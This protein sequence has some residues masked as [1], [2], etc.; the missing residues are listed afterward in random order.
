MD[1]KEKEQLQQLYNR[2]RATGKLNHPDIAPLVKKAIDRGLLIDSN[3]GK[4]RPN[5]AP[6]PGDPTLGRMAPGNTL[7]KKPAYPSPLN[8]PV[9]DVAADFPAAAPLQRS[10]IAKN[11]SPL[12][13]LA[14][15]ATDIVPTVANMVKGVVSIAGGVPMGLT[16]G[17]MNAKNAAGLAA[18]AR[19]AVERGDFKEAERLVKMAE[20]AQAESDAQRD[21]L[22]DMG[23][24]FLGGDTGMVAKM[25][26]RDM[27][28]RQANDTSLSPELRARYKSEAARLSREIPQGV[29]D[30]F[31]ENPIQ[32]ALNA[33][34]IMSPFLRAGV[35]ADIAANSARA[36][37]AA[38][39]AKAARAAGNVAEATRLEANAAKF[40]DAAVNAKK[41]LLGVSTID[42]TIQSLGIP[43][44]VRALDQAASKSKGYNAA[45]A[46]V[47]R[48]A[49]LPINIPGRSNL[50][51][52]LGGK[53]FSA[54]V[55]NEFMDLADPAYRS[56]QFNKAITDV[57]ADKA[58][59][60][61]YGV[62]Y[63]QQPD[64]TPP[65]DAPGIPPVE[66]PPQAGPTPPPADTPIPESRLIGRQVDLPGIEIP[67]DRP[68]V[69]LT[70]EQLDEAGNPIPVRTSQQ[71]EAGKIGAEPLDVAA[72]KK[73]QDEAQPVEAAL[74]PVEPA[75]IPVEPVVQ[76]DA[77]ARVESAPPA[78]TPEAQKAL[79]E[80]RESLRSADTDALLPLVQKHAQDPAREP[81]LAAV[82]DELGTRG[83][84]DEDIAAYKPRPTEP[85]AAPS[86]V[87]LTAPLTEAIAP[88]KM[89]PVVPR[90]EAASKPEPRKPIATAVDAQGRRVT[91]L[92]DG[93]DEPTAQ[94]LAARILHENADNK[95]LIPSA[96][97]ALGLDRQGRAAIAERVQDIVAAA[98]EERMAQGRRPDPTPKDL[99]AWVEK[100]RPEAIQQ[101]QAEAPTNQPERS[102]QR[103]ARIGGEIGP[104][105]EFYKGGAFIATTDLPKR[106]KEKITQAA[107]GV[108]DF[109]ATEKRVPV[110]GEIPIYGRV[111]PYAKGFDTLEIIPGAGAFYGQNE[112]VLGQLAEAFNRGER[113]VRAEDY[114]GIVRQSDIA[115]YIESGT[116]IPEALLEKVRQFYP[117]AI[118]ATKQD[119]LPR[120]LVEAEEARRTRQ[121]TAN[122]A[123]AQREV[124]RDV[125]DV[126][127]EKDAGIARK[128]E[129]QTAQEIGTSVTDEIDARES[130]SLRKAREAAEKEVGEMYKPTKTEEFSGNLALKDLSIEDLAKYAKVT[131]DSIRE[132]GGFGG[133]RSKAADGIKD[134]AYYIE[135]EM[136]RRIYK[137]VT[138]SDAETVRTPT[139]KELIDSLEAEL[140]ANGVDPHKVYRHSDKALETDPLVNR[141]Y[142]DIRQNKHYPDGYTDT[143]AMIEQARP[144]IVEDFKN[145]M[146]PSLTDRFGTGAAAASIIP[147]NLDS[148]I[149]Q[150]AGIAG[151][152]VL[153]AVAKHAPAL[154]KKLHDKLNTRIESM[155]APARRWDTLMSQYIE[156]RLPAEL[157]TGGAERTPEEIGRIRQEIF[158]T[159]ERE[160]EHK[161]KKAALSVGAEFMQIGDSIVQVMDTLG[162]ELVNAGLIDKKAYD[163]NS[164]FYLRRIYEYWEN[165]EGYL[166]KAEAELRAAGMDDNRI[167]AMLG[168]KERYFQ[169]I[170]GRPIGDAE[171]VGTAP[172]G[173]RAKRAFTEREELTA[174]QLDMLREIAPASIRVRRGGEITGRELS[175]AELVNAVR[176]KFAIAPARAN[177]IREAAAAGVDPA[178]LNLDGPMEEA[179][180][181]YPDQFARV[182]AGD[183]L[184]G[185]GRWVPVEGSAPEWVGMEIPLTVHKSLTEAEWKPTTIAQKL[186]YIWKG[187]VTAWNP[188]AYLGNIFGNTILSYLGGGLR[189]FNPITLAK[190][191]ESIRARDEAFQIAMEHSDHPFESMRLEIS[192]RKHLDPAIQYP[193]NVRDWLRK[194][195]GAFK[196]WTTDMYGGIDTLFKHAL[197]IDTMDR[198]EM[199]DPR[200]TQDQRASQAGRL[201][202][203]SFPNFRHGTPIKALRPAVKAARRGAA[204]FIA[205]DASAIPIVAHAFMQHP[206]RVAMFPLLYKGYQDAIDK[207]AQKRVDRELWQE[208][209]R[210]LPDYLK[211]NAIR[212][213]ESARLDDQGFLASARYMNT[214]AFNPV[215]G[216]T[217][218]EGPDGWLQTLISRTNPVLSLL[219]QI[220]A[221]ERIG[222]EMP[223]TNR[224]APTSEQ[225]ADMA[226][227]AGEN[228]I[229]G[230]RFAQSVRSV[231]TGRS[232]YPLR[233]S[234]E[235]GDTFTYNMEPRERVEKAS[236][237]A[238]MAIKTVD[239]DRAA[240]NARLEIT[241]SH[242]DT[243]SAIRKALRQAEA[244]KGAPLTDA[245]EEK[246]RARYIKT[247]EAARQ[248]KMGGD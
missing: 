120:S 19:R 186:L 238:R 8:P 144:I 152:A 228:L 197:F 181:Y 72:M 200:M 199:I 22:F 242:Q 3:F 163:E 247:F 135:I 91:A 174:E 39:A 180:Y 58:Q 202:A 64:A 16:M 20:D 136:K 78:L 121:D 134:A 13:F 28:E 97:E 177:D 159:V 204:P 32:S 243:G 43:G 94:V 41:S 151:A 248:A 48:A 193:S 232:P 244:D 157:A 126:L 119:A 81:L 194:E 98:S 70:L 175:K 198:L 245:E 172:S 49:T 230:Y 224:A 162:Q 52:K 105:G 54:Q 226:R 103:R 160:F 2:L 123:K 147:L 206:H 79:S 237:M 203:Q 153:Y 128:A 239:L 116:P 169:D 60:A 57:L 31:Y 182:K 66:T 74:A 205:W 154:A 90:P 129:R 168:A 219:A 86:P 218:A 9:L 11:K 149:L 62:K 161:D 107:K 47:A 164:G 1:E 76:V 223:V 184:I 45:K 145:A 61:A 241:E 4:P 36:N 56:Q 29:A 220:S 140:R 167:Q 221:N 148:P 42:D 115:R 112:G 209:Q 84:T 133:R 59:Q 201:V 85:T 187:G 88:P 7:A 40:T 77:P 17:A 63:K 37:K 106:V 12:G 139:K 183:G 217:E 114:P 178:T 46:G 240:R 246:V 143:L 5:P 89:E 109:S 212:L 113:T 214:S 132:A 118:T 150:V 165:P 124:G 176:E 233:R 213:P 104:N 83:F 227:F 185:L 87:D 137:A 190:A 191:A 207:L 80:Y 158:D 208:E 156:A 173:R 231:A 166:E 196:D 75:P 117:E 38:T 14:N 96:I 236:Q 51:R 108:E 6:V 73:V 235:D 142:D 211:R 195:G 15:A 23:K 26:T 35:G 155:S 188:S 67:T 171:K 69:D 179:M 24:G 225:A 127:A 34:G 50:G 55:A 192:T 234:G 102:G 95:A 99:R 122:Q 71:S 111:R 30:A 216:I 146:P 141:L 10:D 131:S 138:G 229:P 53:V 92:P 110:V 25:K 215:S 33:V 210:I 18:E 125:S 189:A 21:F 68:Q 27:F 130:E 170:K 222:T 82:V 44:V 65:V 100:N 93:L 101:P